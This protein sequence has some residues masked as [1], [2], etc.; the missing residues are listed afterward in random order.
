[1]AYEV[2]TGRFVGR[3]QELA[4]LSQLLTHAAD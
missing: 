1:M 2:T 4:R 3:T